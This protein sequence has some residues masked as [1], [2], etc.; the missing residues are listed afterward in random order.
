MGSLSGI[1]IALVVTLGV[2]ALFIFGVF[3]ADDGLPAIENS[4]DNIA[5]S[6]SQSTIDHNSVAES[7][8]ARAVVFALDM[9]GSRNDALSV[10]AKDRAQELTN[11]LTAWSPGN[12][13]PFPDSIA[14]VRTRSDFQK[15]TT[16]TAI[17]KLSSNDYFGIVFF[18]ER[19][20]AWSDTLVQATPMNVAKVVRTIEKYAIGESTL[21]HKTNLEGAFG[22]IF[23][24][25]ETGH[26]GEEQERSHA[27]VYIF[28]DGYVSDE[29]A[30]RATKLQAIV[31]TVGI[32]EGCDTHTLRQLAQKS[33]G[34]YYDYR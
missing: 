28:M 32:G 7:P 13:L 23:R 29:I 19:S 3:D 5:E 14:D 21:G 25:I 1:F 2:S 27:D 11:D 33:G 34:R 17:K 6:A 16:T 18:A 12:T 20:E 9:S 4:S 10:S 24:L 22:T 30:S 26:H 8:N 15:A 31:N